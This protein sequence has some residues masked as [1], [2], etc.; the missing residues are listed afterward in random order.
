M[1]RIFL[2][3]DTNRHVWDATLGQWYEGADAFLGFLLTSDLSSGLLSVLPSAGVC[4]I[5]NSV[6]LLLHLELDQIQLYQ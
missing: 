2:R 5:L 4:S 6:T 1:F 3:P